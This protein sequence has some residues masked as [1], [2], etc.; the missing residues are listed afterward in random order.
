MTDDDLEKLRA[1]LRQHEG[2]RLTVYDDTLGVPTI[3]YGRNLRDRGISHAE[4]EMLLNNDI[5]EFIVALSDEFPWFDGLDSV[6]KRALIDMAF[7]VGVEGLRKSP[8][9]LQALLVG[10]YQTAANE[11]LD[12]P[13]KAQVG[14][15]ADT[16]ASMIRTG[17]DPVTA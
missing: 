14:V 7:N 1:L 11:M 3:G 8:K 2:L 12:G 15:R 5:A 4:A 6:R 13:W 17:H 10:S 9:M 16:L